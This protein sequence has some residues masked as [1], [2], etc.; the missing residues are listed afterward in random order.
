VQ[1]QRPLITTYVHSPTAVFRP[2]AFRSTPPSGRRHLSTIVDVD[3]ARLR[4]STPRNV[5][6]ETRPRFQLSLDFWS[7]QPAAASAAH[8]PTS[9]ALICL[10]SYERDVFR[11]PTP[12][13]RRQLS[14][15]WATHDSGRCD[16]VF[17]LTRTNICHIEFDTTTFQSLR[18]EII[19]LRQPP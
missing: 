9:S 4:R 17:S 16:Y 3:R 8:S 18:S 7:P 2:D 12:S 1:R 11:S 14:W 10:P 19:Q 6:W 15:T 5:P 13:G